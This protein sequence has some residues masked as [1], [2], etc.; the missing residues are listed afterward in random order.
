MK[1]NHN[2]AGRPLPPKFTNRIDLE[3]RITFSFWQKV[4]LFFGFSLEIKQT[5]VTEHGCGKASEKFEW[6]IT[7]E[8][9]EE[10]K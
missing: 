10:P 9:V 7:K 4:K 3:R 6:F 5:I 1:Y 2:H 8:L